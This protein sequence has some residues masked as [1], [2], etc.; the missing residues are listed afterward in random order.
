MFPCWL[1]GRSLPSGG[2]GGSGHN[3]VAIVIELDPHGLVAGWRKPEDRRFSL[4]LG[5][6]S[7]LG[8]LAD[9]LR[10]GLGEV[11][12][13]AA[14][15]PGQRAL[16]FIASGG[17]MVLTVDPSVLPA[18]YDSVL[19]YAKTSPAFRARVNQSALRVLVAK[20]ARGLIRS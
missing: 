13:V 3:H 10:R 2:Q 6:L 1:I 8:H 5:L 19:A 16:L 4:N 9:I 20:Q 15:T 7:A 12:Q 11:V 18:M 17:D 14:W